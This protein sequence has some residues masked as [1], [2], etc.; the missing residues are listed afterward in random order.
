VAFQDRAEGS[1]CGG[2]EG[3]KVKDTA[4]DDAKRTCGRVSGGSVS[5]GLAADAVFLGCEVESNIVR[6]EDAV[7][8]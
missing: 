7:E 4:T 3:S 2:S 1:V 5:D 8:R 6:L